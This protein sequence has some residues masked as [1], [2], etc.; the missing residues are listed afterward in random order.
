MDHNTRPAPAQLCRPTLPKYPDAPPGPDGKPLP[1]SGGYTFSE[2]RWWAV[3]LCGRLPVAAV[4]GSPP[5]YWEAHPV[6][7]K[8]TIATLN[9]IREGR[10]K[11]QPLDYSADAPPP[12]PDLKPLVDNGWTY[13]AAVSEWRYATFHD[14]NI[15]GT[16]FWTFERR[17]LGR[18]EA[19]HLT[20]IRAAALP[21][22][23]SK[24]KQSP[25]VIAVK[26][27]RKVGLVPASATIAPDGSV[28]LTFGK[29][30]ANGNGAAEE[31]AEDLRALV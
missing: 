5:P 24:P 7:S 17:Y 1:A 6:R 19:A 10:A 16:G 27:A 11:P 20:A 23:H 13:D 2:G 29:P 14:I 8:L 22:P 25:F 26:D 3:H 12:G 4:L 28:S 18:D 9:A 15:D 21:K 31:T 30:G